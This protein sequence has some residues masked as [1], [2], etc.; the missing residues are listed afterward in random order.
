VYHEAVAPLV[1]ILATN[2]S[3]VDRTFMSVKAEDL[4][5]RPTP[6]SNAML[7]IL[8][9]MVTARGALVKMLG[10]DFDTGLGEL[11]TRGAQVQEPSTY[12]P[13]EKLLEASQEVNA[14]LYARLGALTGDQLAK[15]ASRTFTHAVQTVRD[16][17]AFLV[18]H[19]TYHVGQLGYVRKALGYE[20]VVG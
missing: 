5:K 19:D 9:H 1:F 15:P 16:Q 10:D 3:L 7:W 14:R 12:P 2:D 17:L 20:G 18:M 4:W 11:F 8:G 6:Q 13:R